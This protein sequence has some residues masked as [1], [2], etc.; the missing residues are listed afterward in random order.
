MSVYKSAAIPPEILMYLMM[1]IYAET[2]CAIGV[3]KR[4]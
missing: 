3:L 2:C 1:A 4:K